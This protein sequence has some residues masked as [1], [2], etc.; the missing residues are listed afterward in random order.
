LATC[1]S[2]R[3]EVQDRCPQPDTERCRAMFRH[4]TDLV[5]AGKMSPD[6]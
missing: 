3:A 2:M 5:E 6:P 4:R 1:H